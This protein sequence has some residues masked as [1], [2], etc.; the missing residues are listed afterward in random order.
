MY[1]HLKH[2]WQ[3]RS[4]KSE[5]RRSRSGARQRQIR[6]CF[7]PLLEELESR[8]V[9]TV[10]MLT[11]NQ[12]VGAY[13]INQIIFEGVAATGAG[14]TIAII[15][16]G[17]DSAM[18]NSTDPNFSTSD[19]A[20][21]D[22]TFGLPNPPSFQVVGENGGA[23]PTYTPP[24]FNPVDSGETAMDV[25]W[26]HAIAPGANIVLIEMQGFTDA[27]IA[28]A[29]KTAAKLGASV[30]SMSFGAPESSGDLNGNDGEND[31]L[32]KNAGV[33]FVASSGDL[34]EQGGYPAFSPNVLAV[35]AT[36]LNL[37]PDGSYLSETGWSN[38]PAITS[39][40]ESNNVVT[41]TTATTSGLS[42]GNLMTIQ[43]VGVGGYNGTFTVTSVKSDTS[44]T[45]VDTNTGL[46]AS[47]GG[48]VFGS[49]FNGG[50]AGGSG[51]GIS[52]IAGNHQPAYQQ[53]TVTKVTQSTTLRTIPDVAFVGGSATPVEI[54]DSLG[55][56][57]EPNGGTSLSAPCWAGLVAIADQ[58]LTLRG[59]PVFNTS[60]TLQTAL[61]DT[62]LADFH[63]ITV[64]YNGANAGP[65]YDLVSGIGTPIA[66]LLIPALAGVQA[67]PNVTSSSA[68]G[69]YGPSQS[70]VIQVT[71]GGNV[72]VNQAGGTPTLA[73]NDGATAS[74][75]GG[76]GTNTLTFLQTV[77]PGDTTKGAKLDYT[78]TT[79]LHL[80]GAT[81]TDSIGNPVDVTLAAPGAAGSLGANKAIVIDATTPT[82]TSVTSTNGLYGVGKTI[83]INVSFSEAVKVSTTGGTPSLALSDGGT[84]FY[85]SG[86]GTS[87][88]TFTYT[89]KPGD[90][91]NGGKLDYTDAAALA[92]NGG[93][94][95][96]LGGVPV[97]LTLPAPGLPGSL[98][99]NNS[100]IVD[101]VAPTV[102]AFNVLWGQESYNLLGAPSRDLPWAITGIQVV[103]SK[104]ITSGSAASL[105][106][107]NATGFSGL[108]T[109]TLTWTFGPLANG[110]YNAQLLG[111]GANAL[112]DAAGNP[113]NFGTGITKP[114]QVLF[115]DVNGDGSASPLDLR[116]LNTDVLDHID[117]IFADLNG[118]GVV[119]RRDYT[120]LDKAL[121][122]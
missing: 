13:G 100:V 120:L 26:A 55:N 61:Y 12:V 103:F 25:E 105:A 82:V 88:L 10:P 17:D 21:F 80:N 111:S 93:R 42:A 60:A 101:A 14:Q 122:G 116:I 1:S 40:T 20:V 119:N 53:G 77:K 47:S 112:K 108:G 15:D 66:N 5:P 76:S 113:L 109:N 110:T 97:T 19:L 75:V 94:I 39:A 45:Y 29:A 44:F 9:L 57:F 50:N 24:A 43:G 86:S 31:S 91:T 4:Q 6:R 35:G 3:R 59:Q 96:N 64:G 69:T 2:W 107:I 117:N 114:L 56:G 95:V 89:V 22:K 30:V 34:G 58:G 74:Y 46:G 78:S 18:L 104:P 36:N 52:T 32:F 51:G 8:L 87:T 23:R 7:R 65:G 62:P 99:V 48:T 28:N 115:G 68:N 72:T 71:F 85:T 102:L 33:S 54:Y 84:A 41:I 118:D 121:F 90:T 67:A 11:P 63:D 106:G 79:A 83:T 98:S 73:L 16:P 92:L 49:I 27:D 38:P 81:L 37:N 70:I